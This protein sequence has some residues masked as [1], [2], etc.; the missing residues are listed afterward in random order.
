MLMEG[1]DFWFRRTF[2]PAMAGLWGV[3]YVEGVDGDKESRVPSGWPMKP[4]GLTV[5]PTSAV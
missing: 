2:Y 4:D 1:L 3:G 5:P